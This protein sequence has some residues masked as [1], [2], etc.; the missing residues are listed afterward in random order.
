MEIRSMC[1]SWVFSALFFFKKTTSASFVNHPSLILFFASKKNFSYTY[2]VDVKSFKFHHIVTR[3][4]ARLALRE[5]V[6]IRSFSSPYFPAFGLNV[7]RYG[8]SLRI[9]SE[10]GKLR[11]RKT[12]K[13]DTFHAV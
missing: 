10:C 12:S 11:S 13:T 5:N 8:V 9:L 4:K 2:L 1:L 3:V 7:E 6:R